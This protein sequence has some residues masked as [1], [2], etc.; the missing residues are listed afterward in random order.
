MSIG[1]YIYAYHKHK[2]MYHIDSKYNYWTS[3]QNSE[4]GAWDLKLGL[5]PAAYFS[6][7]Y[8]RSGITDIKPKTPKIMVFYESVSTKRKRQM[9]M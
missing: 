9:E 8:F 5:N 6:K 4:L 3:S 2:Y 1:I 7:K